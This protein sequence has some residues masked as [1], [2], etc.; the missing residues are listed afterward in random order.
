MASQ[1]KETIPAENRYFLLYELFQEISSSLDPQEALNSIID[2]AVKI[3]RASSGSLILVDWE[4]NLLEIKVSRGFIKHIG[5]LRL[6]VGQGITGWVALSGEPMR[7]SDVGSE[8][9]Y[10]KVRDDINAELAVPMKLDDKVIGV[11]NVDSTKREAFRDDDVEL[12]TLLAKQSAQVIRNG[13]LFEDMTRQVDELSTLIE[14]NKMIAHSL[15]VDKILHQIVE[16]TAFLMNSRVC[17]VLLLS[18]DGK[19]LQLKAQFGGS[20]EYARRPNIP[21]AGTIYG[22]VIGEKKSRQV[23]NL[24]EEKH[25]KFGGLAEKEGLHSLLTVPLI[26]GGEAIGLLNIY[27]SNA[28]RF[29][30]SERRLVRTFADL[31]A[32][33]L[34]N[35]RLH[36]KTLQLEDQSRRAG[37]IAAVGE[38][39]VGIAHEIRN[40][41]TIIKMIFEAGSE[42]TAQDRDVI[43]SELARMNKII[44]QLLDYTRL[45]QPEKKICALEKIIDDTLL[46]VSYDFG[47]RSIQINKKI[48]PNLP[49]I[50]ADPV[51]LQQIFLNILMNAAD[52][53]I[54]D[55]EIQLYCTRVA[56]GFVEVKIMDNGPG[57]PKIVQENLFVPFTTTKEKGLGLGL[58]IIKRLADENGGQVFIETQTGKGT[59]VSIHLPVGG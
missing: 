58:S 47:K 13:H 29:D 3:T 32:I 34:E 8:P 38:L 45:K 10:V 59:I 49:G 54:E 44:T 35:A 18:D 14:I 6:R 24:H 5:D 22:K 16:R 40:P 4:N 52:A 9:H 30:R 50:V 51:Q 27:K 43:A 15:S 42:L 20:P 17:S 57:L 23:K 48:A 53:L 25:G 26:A 33:A 7:I 11:L 39:A 46:L 21:V 28:Y 37:R 56:D 55:G 12:L 41:L 1:T 31:C 2:A 19:E 36:E